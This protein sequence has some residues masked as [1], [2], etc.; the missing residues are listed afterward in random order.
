MYSVSATAGRSFLLITARTCLPRSSSISARSSSSRGLDTSNTARIRD[1]LRSLFRALSMP[2]RSTS[3]EAFSLMPAVS[4]SIS[5][6]PPRVTCSS[7]MSL[8]VPAS[9][10]TIAFSYPE[11]RLRIV[12]LPT[13]GLPTIAAGIPLSSFCPASYLFIREER[14]AARFPTS[15]VSLSLSASSTSSSGKSIS[16]AI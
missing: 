2:I 8:V 9:G 5:V 11:I 13:F 6:M 15:S 12:L 3:P 1:D 16:A 14:S 4:A 10:D 7:I